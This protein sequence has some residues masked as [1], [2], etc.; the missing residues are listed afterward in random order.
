MNGDDGRYLTVKMPKIARKT[1][2]LVEGHYSRIAIEHSQLALI[3]QGLSSEVVIPLSMFGTYHAEAL[4]T[5]FLL[6]GT[7]RQNGVLCVTTGPLTKAVF[8]KEGQVVFSGSTDMADRIGNVLVRL[9]MVSEEE[10]ERIANDDDPRRF[11]VKLKS[12]GLISHEQLWEAL[13]VQVSDIC[14]SLVNFPVSTYFF[15]PNC[16]PYDSFSHFRIHPTQVLFQG[17]I[18]YDE[19]N[20]HAGIDPTATDDRGPLEILSAME[21]E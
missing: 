5:L 1:L 7:T 16:V 17:M 4:N 11:G 10:L 3:G 15:L 12:A 19:A 14:H 8:F 6:L 13:R 2:G 21:E 18:Q 20:K 9:K